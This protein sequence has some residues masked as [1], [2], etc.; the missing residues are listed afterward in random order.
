MRWLMEWLNRWF[1]PRPAPKR[2]PAT[3]SFEEIKRTES[4][5]RQAAWSFEGWTEN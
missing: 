2:E 5:E 4:P 1:P 3:M